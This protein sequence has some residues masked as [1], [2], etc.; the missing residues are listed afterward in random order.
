MK[1]LEPGDI[2]KKCHESREGTVCVNAWGEEGVFY[3]PAHVL[4]RGV[5]IM[6]VKQKDGENDKGSHLDRPGIYRVNTGISKKKFRELFGFIPVRPAAGGIVDMP[7]DFTETNKILPHPVY[8]WMGWVCVL[9]PTEDTFEQFM[10]L[11]DEAYELGKKKF[12]KRV[13]SL[14]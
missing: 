13:K 10:S 4:K 7:Y 11:I 12:K 9:N 3:N 1:E 6:T 2:I 5:Y 8:A 14:K